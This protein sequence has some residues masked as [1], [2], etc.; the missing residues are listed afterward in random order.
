M[1]VRYKKAVFWCAGL[2]GLLHVAIISGVIHI[3]KMI[4]DKPSSSSLIQYA[5]LK[6]FNFW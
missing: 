1:S 4:R 2:H 6:T 5:N 3:S